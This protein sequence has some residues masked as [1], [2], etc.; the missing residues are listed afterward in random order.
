MSNAALRRVRATEVLRIAFPSR[1]GFV[2]CKSSGESTESNLLRIAC[3]LAKKD[4]NQY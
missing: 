4:W 1:G 2:S 3:F